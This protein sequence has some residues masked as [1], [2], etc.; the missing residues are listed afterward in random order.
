MFDLGESGKVVVIS[1][2]EGD[3]KPLKYPHM[4]A[5]ADL[6]VVNKIDLMPYVD[7]DLDR[8][9]SD[10]RRLNPGV[11]V[12]PTSAK[13]G[14]NIDQWYGWLDAVS[15]PAHDVSRATQM[16]DFRGDSG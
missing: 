10:V 3:D 5:A 1:V 15:P 16:V 12:T 6:V 7:F 13:T 4:F 2:T 9:V 14:E 11:D 8:F